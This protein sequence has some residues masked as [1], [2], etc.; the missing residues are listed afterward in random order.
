MLEDESFLG[1]EEW[2]EWMNQNPD[3]RVLAIVVIGQIID[4]L[5]VR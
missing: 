4:V 2:A 5:F 1:A 3:V